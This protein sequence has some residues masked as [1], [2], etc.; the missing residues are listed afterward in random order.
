MTRT[1]ELLLQNQ[2]S[3][4]NRSGS[5][6]NT[7]TY[8]ERISPRTTVVKDRA[9]NQVVRFVYH[10]PPAPEPRQE[11]RI[12]TLRAMQPDW[13]P[14]DFITK[15]TPQGIEIRNRQT[16]ALGNLIN[17][18]T[19]ERIN[20]MRAT[21][22]KPD[23]FVLEQSPQYQ[24]IKQQEEQALQNRSWVLDYNDPY[25]IN[26][27][28]DILFNQDALNAQ[29]GHANN[30]WEGLLQRIK[31]IPDYFYKATVAPI[32]GHVENA[33]RRIEQGSTWDMEVQEIAQ[34]WKEI[35]WKNPGEVVKA[36]SSP[37]LFKPFKIAGAVSQ[38]LQEAAVNLLQN[39]GETMDV[40]ANP[41]K[42][43]IIEGGYALTGA[44]YGTKNKGQVGSA[45]L[46]AMGWGGKG[47]VNYDYNTG[48]WPADIALE[49][50]SDPLNWLTFGTSAGDDLLKGLTRSGQ[51]L[52]RGAV[53]DISQETLERITLN[54][55][56]DLGRRIEVNTVQQMTSLLQDGYVST[57]ERAL[58]LGRISP[59]RAAQEI[60]RTGAQDSAQTATRLANRY[61]RI[62]QTT[63]NLVPGTGVTDAAMLRAV[64]R[65]LS[66]EVANTLSAELTPVFL[67]HLDDVGGVT[68]R[69]QLSNALDTLERGLF[70]ASLAVSGFGP[71]WWLG[72]R[73]YRVLQSTWKQAARR[74]D[75]NSVLD[76]LRYSDVLD[77]TAVSGAVPP[78]QRT[79]AKRNLLQEMASEELGLWTRVEQA[80]EDAT[81]LIE[82]HVAED[83]LGVVYFN[84]DTLPTVRRALN[85]IAQSYTSGR[86][87]SFGE[88]V[89]ALRKASDVNEN[90]RPLFQQTQA[91]FNSVRYSQADNNLGELL[92]L[93]KTL[94]RYL[95]KAAT[96]KD[97]I[98]LALR[99]YEELATTIRGLENMDTTVFTQALGN[100]S[101]DVARYLGTLEQASITEF[102]QRVYDNALDIL[103]EL[104]LDIGDAITVTELRNHLRNTITALVPETETLV[105]ANK[106]IREITQMGMQDIKPAASA[107]QKIFTASEEI[108]KANEARIRERMETFAIEE[109]T[110]RPDRLLTLNKELEYI[111]RE[112]VSLQTP[113]DLNTFLASLQNEWE[114]ILVQAREANLDIELGDLWDAAQAPWQ[115]R[116]D[117]RLRQGVPELVQRQ[118]AVLNAI[119]T[120][121][122][123]QQEGRQVLDWNDITDRMLTKKL[124]QKQ[125]ASTIVKSSNIYQMMVTMARRSFEL[126]DLPSVNALLNEVYT[127]QGELFR[128]L[129]H[130]DINTLPELKEYATAV[131]QFQTFQNKVL[132]LADDF[133]N[134]SVKTAFLDALATY[135]AVSLDQFMTDPYFWLDEAFDRAANFLTAGQGSQAS[136]RLSVLFMEALPHMPDQTVLQA[137]NAWNDAWMTDMITQ[138]HP[139]IKGAFKSATDGYTPVYFDTEATG[140]GDRRYNGN[141]L[142][143]AIRGPG[144]NENIYFQSTQL[145]D[146]DVLDLLGYKSVVD[147]RRQHGVSAK[148]LAPTTQ[149]YGTETL[150]NIYGLSEVEGLQYMLDRFKEIEQVTGKPVVLV[151]HNVGQYDNDYLMARMSMNRMPLEAIRQFRGLKSV[152]TLALIRH[153]RG[154]VE[155]TAAERELLS[156]QFLELLDSATQAGLSKPLQPI[157]K[158]FLNLLADTQREVAHQLDSRSRD[159]IQRVNR[160]HAGSIRALQNALQESQEVVQEQLASFA[161]FKRS[162]TG[163]FIRGENVPDG[164]NI[165]SFRNEGIQGLPTT[166]FYVAINPELVNKYF[167]V[168]GTQYVDILKAQ[169]FAARNIEYIATRVGDAALVTSQQGQEAIRY[170]FEAFKSL[171]KTSGVLPEWMQ[172]FKLGL[173]EVDNFAIVQYLYNRIRRKA[174]KMLQAFEAAQ[175]KTLYKE[176]LTNVF[177]RY[178]SRRGTTFWGVHFETPDDYVP[179]DVWQW[180]QPEGTLNMA[181]LSVQDTNRLLAQDVL[182][183]YIQNSDLLNARGLARHSIQ[184]PLRDIWN[185]HLRILN[186]LPNDEALDALQGAW[187]QG[188]NAIGQVEVQQI[189]RMT[190]A[191]LSAYVYREAWGRMILHTPSDWL[192]VTRQN[193]LMA[194]GL[195]VRAVNLTDGSTRVYLATN[196]QMLEQ[197]R[198]L[199]KATLKFYPFYSRPGFEESLATVNEMR[200]MLNGLSGNTLGASWG[201]L[202]N[203]KQMALLDAQF[204]AD[205]QEMLPTMQDLELDKIPAGI[206]FNKSTPG[207]YAHRLDAWNGLNAS[208]NPL[209]Q[210]TL[211]AI[212]HMN[213]LERH[214]QEAAMFFNEDLAVKTSPLTMGIADDPKQLARL[215]NESSDLHM[216]RLIENKSFGRVP[217]AT[218]YTILEV[219]KDP[220]S[221]RAA[222]AGDPILINTE[223]LVM[224]QSDM[225]NQTIANPAL[226]FMNDT[227]T[228]LYR[229]GY[230][231]SLGWPIRNTFDSFFKNFIA[232]GSSLAD[233]PASLQHYFT[234]I[235]L[236]TK[237]VNTQKQYLNFL[238]KLNDNLLPETLQATLRTDTDVF[239]LSSVQ[240]MLKKVVDPDE[241]LSPARDT[242]L[243]EL[244]QRRFVG[245]NNL[246]TSQLEDIFF[247]VYAAEAHLSAEEY[248]MV[249]DFFQNA[250]SVGMSTQ[251]WDYIKKA[252]AEAEGGVAQESTAAQVI[253]R[254][255]GWKYLPTAWVMEA[256]KYIE[257]SMRLDRWLA[258][259]STGGT[260]SEAIQSILKH[261]FDYSNKTTGELYAE[262]LFPFTSFSLKNF[263]YYANV[264]TQNGWLVGALR[265]IL[266]PLIRLDEITDPTQI[267][268]LNKDRSP[269]AWRKYGNVNNLFDQ[270][271]LYHLLNGNII[272]NTD[273][274][275]PTDERRLLQLVF[276]LNPSVMDAFQLFT[277]PA[278]SISERLLPMFRFWLETE[279]WD[280]SRYRIEKLLQNPE[281]APL[282]LQEWLY[283]SL[284]I[285]G[286]MLQRFGSAQK[287]AQRLSQT[288]ELQWA[289]LSPSLFST[290]RTWKDF[291]IQN[292]DPNAPEDL[293]KYW[294]A[295][296]KTQ[297]LPEEFNPYNYYPQYGFPSK[298]EQDLQK[299]GYIRS[300]AEREMGRIYYNLMQYAPEAVKEINRLFPELA[301]QVRRDRVERWGVFNPQKIDPTATREMVNFWYSLYKD[302]DLP[303]IQNPFPYYPQFSTTFK[304]EPTKAVLKGDTPTIAQDRTQ[305][306]YEEYYSA[307]QFNRPIRQTAF[308]STRMARPRNWYYDMYTKTGVSRMKLRMGRTTSQ[309][310]KYRVQDILYAMRQRYY[311]FK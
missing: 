249:G 133:V 110:T 229:A 150:T 31:A 257:W 48:F 308:R 5:F 18:D 212:A 15:R 66:R 43:V 305:R 292:I 27:L 72:R 140:L 112:S 11:Q 202:M 201:D 125:D 180:F 54:A 213:K 58:Q 76:L 190:P 281:Q 234:T 106:A 236:L 75:I 130:L 49:V 258:V 33:Q 184:Q 167:D 45:L 50:V 87:G 149:K 224:L 101:R 186:G 126:N 4:N 19:G 51:Q 92:G 275:D 301:Q 161:D 260:Q 98:D 93:Q 91:I 223:T 22:G 147:F 16:G 55:S 129:Q 47:R 273:I 195:N 107:R 220:S 159:V 77:D 148:T 232:S 247:E 244:L 222:L 177:P 156:E 183:E 274:K 240:D 293:V 162:W 56:Q 204:P 123:F 237:Y 210:Y 310:L 62:F 65:Q 35:D 193:A 71:A 13:L 14:P 139:E 285:V 233:L 171:A 10:G 104:D 81:R 199:P 160:T 172:N 311:Y 304:Q 83:S 288:P 25:E 21:E 1:P 141:L 116:Q 155:V 85:N 109:S 7:G 309:N 279:S 120:V 145:P 252:R 29:Y 9:T 283:S 154:A 163:S 243:A 44:D 192:S 179:Q 63:L 175:S 219:T 166:G 102:I 151:G 290:L 197:V 53:D 261:H 137:H 277:D 132:A 42:A 144:V 6:N 299:Y 241:A 284:P 136:Q 17:P 115:T 2:E 138:Y 242:V 84:R 200:Q 216:V 246:P 86:V 266:M 250:P 73:G 208:T 211:G 235:S 37:N 225:W 227:I 209:K 46:D 99:V 289:A 69:M 271:R 205:M 196:R 24:A 203:R 276:K 142:Q 113:A 174:S 263:R 302:F 291:D 245:Q 117:L 191:Q 135:N 80:L 198:Q 189:L 265:D 105:K 26:S 68:F 127:G 307:A 157:N 90:L 131:M 95:K 173:N 124:R 270:A 28:A 52:T 295:Q 296:Y 78:A 97:D 89:E 187:K 269:Q 108:D 114:T 118:E 8:T 264:L 122:E 230:L 60:M 253:A 267:D 303:P 32:Q 206:R 67:K 231:S 294:Y 12:Q 181:K 82:G 111:L 143:A 57:Y 70:K 218:P 248:R 146:A 36:I 39:V 226:R 217:D 251:Y 134:P 256:N 239:K 103:D 164:Y 79:L 182:A 128:M 3:Q 286:T 96:Q 23:G 59:K 40:F 168:S 121:Q 259:Q 88:Y 262:V 152:D 170:F 287:N 228:R 119:R 278:G 100:M 297:G 306:Q 41:V 169:S 194:R 268:Y 185:K 30:P 188:M 34:D 214:V 298:D 153:A 207:T 255:L 300:D 282:M 64:R 165:M 280:D 221:I 158:D 176:W 20:Y 215:L 254:A 74:A 178:K 94:D 272:F 61:A 238:A 38:G